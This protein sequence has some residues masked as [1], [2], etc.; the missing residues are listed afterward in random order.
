M[1]ADKTMVYYNI[2]KHSPERCLGSV[3]YI[4]YCFYALGL[5]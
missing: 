1:K 4:F 5:L 2:C 3:L